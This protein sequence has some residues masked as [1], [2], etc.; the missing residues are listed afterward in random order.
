MYEKGQ[1]GEKVPNS[2][3]ISF[4]QAA[5][6]QNATLIRK[7]RNLGQSA[8]WE[9]EIEKE[10]GNYSQTSPLASSK[11]LDSGYADDSFIS[12]GAKHTKTILRLVGNKCQFHVNLRLRTCC[13]GLV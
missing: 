7:S 11:R 2:F 4:S 12:D 5:D 9:K 1:K 13:L 8:A 6:W 3:S 10:F